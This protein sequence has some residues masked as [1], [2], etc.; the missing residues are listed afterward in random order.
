MKEPVPTPE[1]PSNV[2][3]RSHIRRGL[4][5]VSLALASLAAIAGTVVLAQALYYDATLIA[6][7][8]TG[9]GAAPNATD[10]D[11]FLVW[12]AVVVVGG[13]VLVV[14]AMLWTAVPVW[15]GGLRMFGGLV[16]DVAGQRTASATTMLACA[17]CNGLGRAPLLRVAPLLVVGD[18]VRPAS[19][20]RER[21]RGRR[22]PRRRRHRARARHRSRLRPE[23]APLGPRHVTA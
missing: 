16:L 3:V 6:E 12:I 10:F 13:A 9:P 4:A 20:H 1:T 11:R 19:R 7:L 2:S 14:T 21:R 23:T 18:R 17:A 8:A 5:L 15:L 22:L